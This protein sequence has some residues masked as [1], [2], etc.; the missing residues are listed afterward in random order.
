MSWCVALWP[1]HVDPVAFPNP[2][3]TTPVA[4]TM[5]WGSRPLTFYLLP[6]A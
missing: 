5:C 3:A 4:P 1:R 2:L 6:L